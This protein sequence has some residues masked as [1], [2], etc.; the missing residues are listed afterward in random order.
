M[1]EKNAILDQKKIKEN[2]TYFHII[3]F[4]VQDVGEK[5]FHIINTIQYIGEKCHFEKKKKNCNI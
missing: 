5:Y 2:T 1:L 4:T 3:E